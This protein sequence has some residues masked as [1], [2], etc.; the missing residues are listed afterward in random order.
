[1]SRDSATL[2]I[3][4]IAVPLG[5][6]VLALAL[7]STAR[8]L[9][10]VYASPFPLSPALAYR[11]APALGDLPSGATVRLERGV[12]MPV[13]HTVRRGQTLES[14]LGRMGFSRG[15]GHE[16]IRALG[17]H[18]DLRR[19]RPG[20]LLT[21]FLDDQGR[22]AE[23]VLQVGDRGRVRA[24]PEG[25][26]GSA[27]GA[28]QGRWEP[29]TELRRIRTVRGEIEGSLTGA[30]AA[31][32]APVALA[33]AMADVLQW[34][35]DFNRDLRSGDRFEILYEEVEIEGRRTT[36]GDILALTYESRMGSSQ[37]L[38]AYRFADRE[39]YYDGE[40][41]PLA[42]LFLRSPL[43][44]SRVTSHFSR[45]RFHPVLKTHRPH[46]GVDYGAPVGT[47]VRATAHGTVT[48]AGW[49]RGG[50]RT[51]KVRHAKGYLTGYLHLS[52]FADG[53]RPGVRVSQGQVVGYVGSSGLAT[54]PHLDYRV[55]HHGRW[56]DPLRI[57][58]VKADPLDAEEL[59]RFQG[60]RDALRASLAHGEPPDLPRLG[61]PAADERR[62]ASAS[63]TGT[64][65]APS[66]A[67][68]A[69]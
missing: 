40:G 25:G 30:V 57:D 42:K 37:T 53:V 2:R 56:I 36:I 4:R 10:A 38:E 32:E 47:P 12:L 55:Q 19:L 29:F 52:R 22:I 63:A 66:A 49:N 54:G 8:R 41:R 44:F 9:E 43:Q 6:L 51:V 67:G 65:R 39:G 64:A 28:W 17:E 68:P 24:R 48:F 35:L 11:S 3:L 15:E 16:V 31:A 45:S 5:L 62:L 13:E 50:G 34:D 7:D 26:A 23:L 46:Y 61:E 69:D 58:N 20:E 1:M 18:A 60:W 14:M 59:D 33:Y 21:A 27:G